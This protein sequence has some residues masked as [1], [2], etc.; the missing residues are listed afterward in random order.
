MWWCLVSRC[1]NTRWSLLNPEAQLTCL[2]HM[3]AAEGQ[4]WGFRAGDREG[5][6]L[7]SLCDSAGGDRS[8][9]GEAFNLPQAPPQP[10]LAPPP[11]FTSSSTELLQFHAL[12]DREALMQRWAFPGL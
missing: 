9:L 11:A 8:L 7:N 1:F 4:G 12:L 2:G 10:L 3:V 5:G 6:F